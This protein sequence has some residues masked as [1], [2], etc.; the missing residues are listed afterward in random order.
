MI[1]IILNSCIMYCSFTE[2]RDFFVFLPWSVHLTISI[3][4]YIAKEA[5]DWTVPAWILTKVNIFLH[6]LRVIPF[7][8]LFSSSLH[9]RLITFDEKISLKGDSVTNN[10]FEILRDRYA[11]CSCILHT[12]D[13]VRC[14]L[15]RRRAGEPME[16]QMRVR[17]RVR[18]RLNEFSSG[19]VRVCMIGALI[20]ENRPSRGHRKGIKTITETERRRLGENERKR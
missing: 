13:T 1:I 14:D 9:A 19:R 18:N 11:A 17:S 2:A 20:R 5:Q 6:L 10:R 7:T 12:V 3:N 4:S 8:R 15:P 16:F